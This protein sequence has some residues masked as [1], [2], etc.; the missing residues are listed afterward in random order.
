[1]RVSIAAVGRLKAGPERALVERYLERAARAGPAVGLT[2]FAV[3]EVAESRAARAEARCGE[4]AGALAAAMPRG[5][6]VIVLD[7]TGE[8]WTSR[9]LAD[10][11]GRL[12]DAG[13]GDLVVAIGGP[14]GHGPAMR[15]VGRHLVSLGRITLPHQ[16][17]RVI[18]AEQLYRAVTLLSGHPYHRD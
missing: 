3:A 15:D 17:V 8:P 4:E 6:E 7:E 10:A 16:L 14:D 2:G 13:R 11:L 5:A 1:V 9:G 18:L 12:R